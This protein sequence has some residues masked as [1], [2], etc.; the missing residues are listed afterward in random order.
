MGFLAGLSENGGWGFLV[1][2]FGTYPKMA[3]YT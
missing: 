2:V 3:V 1:G